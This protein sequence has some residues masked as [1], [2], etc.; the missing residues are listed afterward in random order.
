MET[1]ANERARREPL[2]RYE[3]LDAETAQAVDRGN[4]PRPRDRKA[5]AERHGGRVAA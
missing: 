4:G 3:I 5:I 2:R 1:P